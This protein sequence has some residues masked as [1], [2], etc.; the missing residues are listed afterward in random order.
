MCTQSTVTETA[1]V[2]QGIYPTRITNY[3]SQRASATACFIYQ[4]TFVP[5]YSADIPVLATGYRWQGDFSTPPAGYTE[6]SS[7]IV[8]GTPVTV[9]PR[10]SLL[11]VDL[12]GSN[13]P[14][15]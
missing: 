5:N 4:S 8:T 13:C 6:V 7:V 3:I 2:T 10:Y 15:P 12:S 11:S 14:T 1:T 9:T